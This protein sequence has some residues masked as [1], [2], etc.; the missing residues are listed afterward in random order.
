MSTIPLLPSYI[1][2]A[3]VSLLSKANPCAFVFDLI[4]FTINIALFLF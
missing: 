3:Y 4:P 1:L 2:E